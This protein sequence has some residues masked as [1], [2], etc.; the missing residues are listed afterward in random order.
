MKKLSKR[1][2]IKELRKMRDLSLAARK[3]RAVAIA[4]AQQEQ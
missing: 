1:E 3:R 2:Q 4:Q